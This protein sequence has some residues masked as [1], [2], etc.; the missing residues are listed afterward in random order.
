MAL[1]CDIDRYNHI[2]FNTTVLN[3]MIAQYEKLFGEPPPVIT[4]GTVSVQEIKSELGEGDVING[5][6]RYGEIPMIA[7]PD[8]PIDKVAL[9]ET[10]PR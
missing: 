5:E 2:G 1:M 8:M 6:E 10:R 3:R 7:D 4:M 9:G